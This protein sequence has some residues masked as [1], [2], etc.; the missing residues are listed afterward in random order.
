MNLKQ[1]RL[2]C[3]WFKISA[4][5]KTRLPFI[6]LGERVSEFVFGSCVV[7]LVFGSSKNAGHPGIIGDIYLGVVAVS[8][9]YVA[10]GYAASTIFFGLIRRSANSMRQ[11]TIMACLFAAHLVA[12]VV[13]IGG[14][15][16]QHG[17]LLAAI[18][19]PIVWLVNFLGG[20]LLNFRS[21]LQNR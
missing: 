6:W 4:M 10:S 11:S 13:L 9:F 15:E 14:G 20:S 12:F 21:D 17:W 1:R 2:H 16:L 5:L 7:F 19:I 8:F 3:D 18:A